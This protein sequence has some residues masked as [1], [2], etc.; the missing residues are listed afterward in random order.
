MTDDMKR[1]NLR[2]TEISRPFAIGIIPARFDST[3]LPGKLLKDLAGQSVLERTWHRAQKASLIDR[4]VIAAGDKKIADAARQFGADVV[5][6]FED[7]PSGSDRIYR[8]LAKLYPDVDKPDI[9]VNIQGDEPFL[10]PETVDEAVRKLTEDSGAGVA[11]AITPIS[12]LEEFTDPA[13]VKVVTDGVD[14]AM[15]FS[16]SPIPYGWRAGAEGAFRHIGL[17]VY[18]TEALEL[19]VRN[20]PCWQEIL[21]K[22][23]QLRLLNLGVKIAVILVYEWG[24]GIDTQG[25]LDKARA[26]IEQDF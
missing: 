4:V 3:R 13:A 19:F 11:T 8:A 18:R 20:D 6:V 5:E 12:E 17:Y 23:E 21:E 16:R 22:L 1:Q 25:D 2:P 26:L 24:M 10:S 14:H 7:V 9:V 15:Y